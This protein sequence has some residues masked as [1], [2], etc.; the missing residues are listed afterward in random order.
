MKLRVR[1]L[2]DTPQKISR[3]IAAGVFTAFT[4]F[5]GLHFVL[6]AV[7]AR[8]MRGNILAALL[9]TFFGNPLTYIPIGVVALSTGYWVLGL[10]YNARFFGIG[11]NIPDEFC[12]LGCRFGRAFSDIWANIRAIFG[13][14]KAEWAGLREFYAEVFLPYLVGG[15][16]P[17]LVA[18]AIAYYLSLPVI[19]AYQNRRRKSLRA[20]LDQLKKKG[21]SADGSDA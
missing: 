19:S 8:L 13:P 1:R 16:L 10:P 9:G 12:A 20:K 2:P 18:A 5:Y 21:T 11:R 4:P 14:A 6:A 15:I 17:G 7:I 3:G